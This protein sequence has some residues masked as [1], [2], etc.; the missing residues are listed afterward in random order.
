MARR[1]HIP[2]TFFSGSGIAVKDSWR[3][4]DMATKNWRFAIALIAIV[5]PMVRAD[6]ALPDVQKLLN[7]GL[8][9]QAEQQLSIAL[10]AHPQDDRTRLALAITRIVAATQRLA[11]TFNEYGIR[12]DPAPIKNPNRLKAHSAR[13]ALEV[14]YVEIDGIE[15]ILAEIKDDQVKLT[16]ALRH[17]KIDRN[18]DGIPEDDSG[19]WFPTLR[20]SNPKLVEKNPDLRITFD[21]ADVAWLRGYIRLTQGWLDLLLSLDG[22]ELFGILAHFLFEN[23][24]APKDLQPNDKLFDTIK[25]VPVWEPARWERARR[26]LLDVCAR[27]RETWKYVTAET[28]DD[29]ELLPNPKQTGAFQVPIKQEMI[30]TW[31]ELVGDVECVLEGTKLLPPLGTQAVEPNMGLN[32]RKMTAQPPEK[33]NFLDATPLNA[34]YIERGELI[35]IARWNRASM[36]FGENFP[37]FMIWFN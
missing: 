17:V 23:P 37:M 29:F 24:D 3:L 34:P 7:E 27:S 36:V 19:R 4:N 6:D 25:R 20:T 8:V 22:R 5:S 21:R 15:R 18:G 9:S 28:D 2:E 14:F 26:H 33:V 16:L 11:Q 30:E 1:H 13:R 31:L 32:L 12:N 35:D 10:A